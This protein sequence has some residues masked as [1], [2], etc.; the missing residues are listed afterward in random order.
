MPNQFTTTTTSGYGNRIVN[1]IKGV[2]IGFILFI[3]SFGLLYWNEGRVDLS[4][5]AKTAREISSTSVTADLSLDRKFVSTTGVV[6]SDELIGDNL[7]LQPDT[8]IAVERKVE[9]YAWKE[10]Q[11][12][13]SKT[14]LGGSETTETTYTYRKEWMEQPESSDNFRH[15]EGHEN[16][17][18]SL[19]SY[20]NKAG[21]ATIGVYNFDPSRVTLPNFEKVPLNAQ[22]TTLSTGAILAN[23]GYLFI[24]KSE[25]GTFE[26]P[27]IGDLRVS[28]YALRLG[29]TGTIFGAWYG[30]RIESYFDQDGNNLYRLFIGTREE[31]V[32]TLHSEYTMM[33]WILR[34]A[35]FLAMWFGL[36]AL[37]GPISVLLDILPIFGSLSRSLIGMVTFFVSLVL[38]IVTILVSMLIHNLIALIIALVVTVA[39]LVVFLVFIKKKKRVI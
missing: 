10:D 18:K 13:T 37:F 17:Q 1:S 12:T 6:D 39:A 7:F 19:D 16:P 34:L 30:N 21:A 2:V 38:T 14:N 27:S 15:P 23:D 28:Y 35:G 31:G 4:D 26:D 8:F 11:E 9:M 33:L 32:A 24:R 25:S 36:L 5:I 22:N 3:A 20:T 29:F